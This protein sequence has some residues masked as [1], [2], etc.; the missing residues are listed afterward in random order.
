MHIELRYMGGGSLPR[1]PSSSCYLYI[2]G[3]TQHPVV[4]WTWELLLTEGKRRQQR[5]N[6]HSI[7]Q[8]ALQMSKLTLYLK[9][10]SSVVCPWSFFYCLTVYFFKK[11]QTCVLNLLLEIN[12][13]TLFCLA[14]WRQLFMLWFTALLA[15]ILWLASKIQSPRVALFFLHFRD[16][17]I[18]NLDPCISLLN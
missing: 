13:Y 4:G 8:S 7:S 18:R 5:G 11:S 15:L 1:L 10:L 12:N 16:H 2:I 3:E 9:F 17:H 14:L 6:L